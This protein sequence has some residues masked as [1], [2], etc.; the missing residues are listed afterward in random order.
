MVQWPFLMFKSPFLMFSKITMSNT[1]CPVAQKGFRTSPL[2]KCG[3]LANN[4]G[5]TGLRQQTWRCRSNHFWIHKGSMFEERKSKGT[6]NQEIPKVLDSIGVFWYLDMQR[7]YTMHRWRF[8]IIHLSAQDV[9]EA[10]QEVR[11]ISDLPL[12]AVT[13]AISSGYR[14]W[15]SWCCGFQA[16]IQIVRFPLQIV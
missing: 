10:E 16:K 12:D 8:A 2:S 11:H 4:V 6:C 1:P 15:S 7:E 14:I 13:G 3:T 5:R 9:A